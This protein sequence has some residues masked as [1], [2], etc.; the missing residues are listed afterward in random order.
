M[1]PESASEVEGLR[2]A[3][4]QLVREL[5]FL[6]DR[7]DDGQQSL[8]HSQCHCLLELSY[9][10]ELTGGELSEILQLDKSS[11]SRAVAGL[12]N[13]GLLK[14]ARS[15]QLDD[16]RR[17][18]MRLTRAGKRTVDR[19]NARA[20]AE[21]QNALSLLDPEERACVCSGLELYARSLARARRLR[22]IEVRPIRSKDNAAMGTIIRNVMTEFGA[23][24]K[25][26]SIEDPEVSNMSKAYRIAGHAFYVATEGGSI[27]G[28]AGIGPLTG[29]PQDV[30]ELR[31]MYLGSAARGLGLGRRLLQTCLDRARQLGYKR[32][33]LETLEHMLGA[34]KLYERFGFRE[35]DAP[36]GNTGHCACDSWM[37]LDFE[38]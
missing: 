31:K 30:C 4:R 16:S 22:G 33:Y 25:G 38:Q 18:P 17:R 36:L 5:G 11:T 1:K 35:L 34:R 37:L 19:I 14:Q 12:V 32:C 10:E 23:V 6:V 24:G 2:K 15:S 20:N 28:G 27:L 21:V 9:R 7:W 8:S 26:Y 13:D 3:S 29:G